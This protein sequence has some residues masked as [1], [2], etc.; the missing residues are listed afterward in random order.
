M[1]E[2]RITLWNKLLE[3]RVQWGGPKK[4]FTDIVK[5]KEAM[6]KCNSPMIDSIQLEKREVTDWTTIEGLDMVVRR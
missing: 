2:Y 4:T 3:Q 5:A 6:H 1:I